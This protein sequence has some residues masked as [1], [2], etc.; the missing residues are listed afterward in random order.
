MLKL[1]P[2]NLKFPR[3]DEHSRVKDAQRMDAHN[4]NIR[5]IYVS[6][7]PFQH[8][9]AHFYT[10]H[11][12]MSPEQTFFCLL[13]STVRISQE[14]LRGLIRASMLGT[15]KLTTPGSSCKRADASSCKLSPELHQSEKKVRVF[16][17]DKSITRPEQGFH[18]LKK[19]KPP[20]QT[21]KTT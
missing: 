19:E 12:H 20:K 17:L 13:A 5:Q 4:I 18:L 16:R 8:K 15:G 1:I 7:S 6:S 3:G 2:K 21:D 11:V 14:L 9:S 10:F